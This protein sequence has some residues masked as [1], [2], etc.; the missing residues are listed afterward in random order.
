VTA[1]T[2]DRDL[3]AAL[4]DAVWG[5]RRVTRRVVRESFP[6]PALPPSEAELLALVSR[7]EGT[8]V[9]EA[10][11]AL[12]LAP[13]TVSTLVGRLARAGLLERRPDPAD[14][15]AARLHLTVAG[16]TRV[17]QFHR[18]R[19]AVLARALDTLDDHE[20]RALAAAL[21]AMGRLADSLE[22]IGS[23]AAR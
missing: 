12:Q 23:G 5:L 19:E 16:T 15:R 1:T 10:A 17:R 8:T 2:T 21:P 6:E 14:R 7:A 18:H 3:G 4:V 11:Q 22:A 20:R 13:N 9:N